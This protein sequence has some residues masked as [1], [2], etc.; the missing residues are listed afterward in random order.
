MASPKKESM[1]DALTCVVCFELTLPPW[2]GCVNGH[3]TCAGCRPQLKKNQCPTCRVS[4]TPLVRMRAVEAFFEQAP[5]PLIFSCSN[6][7]CGFHGE[8]AVMK[9]HEENCVARAVWCPIDIHAVPCTWRGAKSNLVAHL[10]SVHGAEGC[11]EDELLWLHQRQLNSSVFLL[12]DDRLALTISPSGNKIDNRWC[13]YCADLQSIDEKNDVSLVKLTCTQPKKKNWY[14]QCQLRADALNSA[15]KFKQ[16]TTMSS[17]T[18]NCEMGCNAEEFSLRIESSVSLSP[19]KKRE[20]AE[21]ELPDD[22]KRQK[23]DSG[24][25][26]PELVIC[27]HE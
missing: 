11:R 15:S 2:E 9:A 22:A 5:L 23:R 19:P 6:D 27:Y 4:L 21:I 10:K 24:R 25:A 13:F 3:L 17:T 16:A 8:W 20:R 18:S 12:A 26:A 14:L 1:A 7:S